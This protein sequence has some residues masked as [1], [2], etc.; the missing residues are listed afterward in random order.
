[1]WNY[2]Q[3]GGLFGIGHPDIIGYIDGLSRLLFVST[4]HEMEL[5]DYSIQYSAGCLLALA[6]I[7]GIAFGMHFAGMECGDDGNASVGSC[8]SRLAAYNLS[9]RIYSRAC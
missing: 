1:M 9:A 5:A 8:I 7:L 3:C 2:R 4:M 6:Q